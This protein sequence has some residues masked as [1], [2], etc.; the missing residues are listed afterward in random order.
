MWGP[1]RQ[2]RAKGWGG[3][4]L[5]GQWLQDKGWAPLD[6]P[7]LRSTEGRCFTPCYWRGRRKPVM[8][9]SCEHILGLTW[10]L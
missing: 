4:G 8:K 1:G 6:P 3:R 7:L 10:P 5:Q 2:C 9:R